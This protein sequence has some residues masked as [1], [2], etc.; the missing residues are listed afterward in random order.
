MAGDALVTAKLASRDLTPSPPADRRTLARRAYYDLIGLPMSAEDVQKITSDPRDASV[1][2]EELVDRLL[3]SP[4]F[5]VRWARYWTRAG[6]TADQ[7]IRVY[8]LSIILVIWI[9]WT[10][11]AKAT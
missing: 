11:A 7:R 4:Q 2:Y 10:V 6:I 3:A 5:G 1:V 9:Y 8:R